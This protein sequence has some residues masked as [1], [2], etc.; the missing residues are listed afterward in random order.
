MEDNSDMED[1]KNDMKDAIGQELLNVAEVQIVSHEMINTL[2]NINRSIGKSKLLLLLLSQSFTTNYWVRVCS[3]TNFN[4][5][6]YS[7]SP[8]IVPVLLKKDMDIPMGLKSANPLYFY[9]RDRYYTDALKKLL[10]Q[11]TDN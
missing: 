8:L 9:R 3:L 1:F 4:D 7:K 2:D 10:S 11:Y 5:A 6:L